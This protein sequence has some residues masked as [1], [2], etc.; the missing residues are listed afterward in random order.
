MDDGKELPEWAPEL[1]RLLAW[2]SQC[3]SR[4]YCQWAG[5]MECG[6]CGCYEPP[7]DGRE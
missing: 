2:W 7:E 4:W 1:V 5:R 6:T 3:P